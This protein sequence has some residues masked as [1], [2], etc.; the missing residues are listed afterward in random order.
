M[1]AGHGDWGRD[2]LLYAATPYGGY[3]LAELLKEVPGLRYQAAAQGVRRFRLGLGNDPA[4]GRLLASL[5]SRLSIIDC[6]EK[7][8]LMQIVK[9]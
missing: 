6:A 4:K 5:R 2:G 1:V 8:D 9:M 3:R 7:P